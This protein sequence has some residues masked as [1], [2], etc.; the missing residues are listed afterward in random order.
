MSLVIVQLWHSA[1]FILLSSYRYMQTS[2]PQSPNFHFTTILGAPVLFV[3]FTGFFPLFFWIKIRWFGFIQC[4]LKLKRSI[5]C[6]RLPA[7]IFCIKIFGVPV[8]YD[9]YFLV[10]IQETFKRWLQSPGNVAP[11]SC[12]VTSPPETI[13]L[14]VFF[15]KDQQNLQGMENS[16]TAL[17]T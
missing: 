10:F 1:I 3:I 15:C 2:C 12:S 16:S 7:D 13:A 6:F 11:V 4:I 5:R 8:I 14:V 9:N 17:S